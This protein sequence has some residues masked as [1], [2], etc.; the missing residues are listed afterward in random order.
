MDEGKRRRKQLAYT[1]K[2]IIGKQEI[3]KVTTILIFV[4]G[5]QVIIGIFLLPQPILHFHHPQ[6]EPQLGSLPGGVICFDCIVKEGFFYLSIIFIVLTFG[7]AWYQSK[8][9]FW[10]FPGGPV[11][12]TR[13]FHC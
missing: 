5:H 8:N 10:E 6:P 9:L 7:V 4:T 1:N 13:C 2:H 12:R 3:C 11:L